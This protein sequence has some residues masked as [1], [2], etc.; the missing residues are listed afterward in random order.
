MKTKSLN[1]FIYTFALIGLVSMITA[2]NTQSEND[3]S[4]G[5]FQVSTT[6][7]DGEMRSFIYETIINTSTGEIISRKKVAKKDYK[8]LKL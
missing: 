1:Y 5:Q 7:Y 6:T 8:T 4:V 3:I 2:F